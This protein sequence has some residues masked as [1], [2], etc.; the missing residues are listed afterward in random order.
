MDIHIEKAD[1]YQGLF[2]LMSNNYDL[3]LTISEMNEIIIESQKVVNKNIV[4]TEEKMTVTEIVDGIE[5]L[6][7]VLYTCRDN[8]TKSKEYL[9]IENTIESLCKKLQNRE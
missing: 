6:K 2:N 5:R 9:M 4:P 7:K 3:T 1:Q 8:P